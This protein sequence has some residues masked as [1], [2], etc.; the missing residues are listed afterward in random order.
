M[1]RSRIVRRRRLAGASLLALTFGLAGAG[2]ALAQEAAP[3]S[4]VSEVVITGSRIVANGFT[5]PSP[6][7][8]VSAERMQQRAATNVGDVLN[9]LPAFRGTQTPAAQGLTG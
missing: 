6:V 4:A 1:D 9:E 5:A 7:S 2:G 3:G 8:V